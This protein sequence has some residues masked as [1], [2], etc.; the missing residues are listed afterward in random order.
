MLRQYIY[1]LMSQAQ[2][3]QDEHG[4]YIGHIPNYQ[5][6]YAQGDNW[7]EAR[8]NLAD[9]VELV[10]ATKLAKKDPLITQDLQ[11]FLAQDHILYA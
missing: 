1:Y 9:A 2:Y 8:R 11:Q 10:I 3:E 7:E 6:C 5:W 4:V